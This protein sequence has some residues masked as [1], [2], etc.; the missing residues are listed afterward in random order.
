MKIGTEGITFVY[1]VS[2]KKIKEEDLPFVVMGIFNI[3]LDQPESKPIS[4]DRIHRASRPQNLTEDK[5]R[6]VLCKLHYFEEKSAIMKKGQS[7]KVIDYGV[8]Q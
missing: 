2:Q 8:C 6:D 3:I 7:T 5:P 1:M 4:F